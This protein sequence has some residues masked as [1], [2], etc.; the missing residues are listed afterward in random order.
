MIIIDT[1]THLH[2]DHYKND[3]NSILTNAMESGVK[4]ILTIGTDVESSRAS[5]MLAKLHPN[6][7][8][9]AA[10]LHPT[11]CAKAA[12]A[13]FNTI[14]ELINKNPEFVAVGEIGLDLYWK[15]VPL[16]QQLF[17]FEA[18]HK[19]SEEIDKP[20]IVHNRDALAEMREY[21][22]T[23]PIK[24]EVPG[25]MHSF[26]GGIEDAKFYLDLGFYISF[27]G[28]VTFKNFKNQEAV[29]Y[30][31]AE[32]LLL[33]TDS[34]FLAPVPFRGKRNEPAYLKNTL[35]KLAEIKQ[36]DVENLAE[37]TLQNTIDLFKINSNYSGSEVQRFRGSRFS[38]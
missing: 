22:K 16:K 24:M 5:L 38:A 2:F 18:M 32:R 29:K 13:D 28:V 30:I 34:P 1:H 27:T 15:D 35:L 14:K 31:P 12:N 26:A 23:H 11:D 6:M 20:M 4:K 19:I 36:M 9:A 21:F 8:Y 33:E 7:L 37:I 25:V 17:V 10:G 3:L